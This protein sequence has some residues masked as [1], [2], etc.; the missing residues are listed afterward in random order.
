[1]LKIVA[2]DVAVNVFL[3]K[4]PLSY[5]FLSVDLICQE[6][7]ILLSSA[8]VVLIIYQDR[9]FFLLVRAVV[10]NIVLAKDL[11]DKMRQFGAN[12]CFTIFDELLY[13]NLFMP[14]RKYIVFVYGRRR[15]SGNGRGSASC[16]SA[17]QVSATTLPCA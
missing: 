13:V 8:I 9:G 12:V 14:N 2:T 3:V 6:E 5:D 15:C 16:R 10:D 1:V 7:L 4:P 11:K 17:R